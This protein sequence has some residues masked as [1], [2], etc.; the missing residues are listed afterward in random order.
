MAVPGLSDDPVGLTE[1]DVHA[2]IDRR[3]E[4]LGLNTAL[5]TRPLPTYSVNARPSAIVAK[6]LAIFVPDAAVGSRFQG[7]DGVN[8]VALG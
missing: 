8:W 4:E 1:R 3:I 7:S 5:A 6:G 2:L